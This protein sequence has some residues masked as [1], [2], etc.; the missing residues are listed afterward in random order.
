[1][2]RCSAW[3]HIRNSHKAIRE[4]DRQSVKEHFTKIEK[5]R[6]EGKFKC[7]YCRRKFDDHITAL[8]RHCLT[9]GINFANPEQKNTEINVSKLKLIYKMFNN[10]VELIV[11]LVDY[12]Y[13]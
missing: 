2:K 12:I 10:V 11:L 5:G 8:T 4:H 9:H 1:M 3:S 7:H 6:D 13:I